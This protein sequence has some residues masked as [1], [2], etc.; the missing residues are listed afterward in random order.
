M[1]RLTKF[2]ETHQTLTP[3]DTQ[4]GAIAESAWWQ[5]VKPFFDD[6]IWQFY[7]DRIVFLN[8][9]FPED[10]STIAY[11]NIIRSFVINLKTK[12]R[13]YERI[14]EV[15]QEDYNPLWNVDGVT[16]IITK[17][18]HTGTDTVA[19]TGYDTSA[20][21]GSDRVVGSGNATDAQSGSDIN[22]LSGRDIDT[23]SGQ[24][25]NAQSGSDT[26]TSSL[27]EI[28]TVNYSK[29]DHTKTGSETI[30]SGGNDVNTKAVATFDSYQN[31]EGE[32]VTN[33]FDS[34]RDTLAHG[35]V[36]THNYNNVKDA[37]EFASTEGIDQDTTSNTQFGKTDTMQYGKVDTMQ[38]GK[39]DTTTYGKTDTNTYSKTDTTT[40]GKTDRMTYNSQSQDTKALEDEHLEMQIR[41]GNIGVT[42]SQQLL[43]A[44][45][46][47]WSADRANFIKRV[48]RDCVNIVTYAVEG[49]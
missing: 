39:T 42:M 32:L 11:Q 29:D 46:N 18:T 19:K 24:D 6:E 22:T 17:D 14:Y 35:K 8:R 43:D 13:Q 12:A 15:L 25:R 38:Y 23:L 37:H 36:D 10:D 16:G 33:L 34:E 21:S 48:V 2:L 4:M 7:D 27:D 3:T 45:L 31:V 30:S 49:V 40:Y 26:T 41:Q 9:K 28:K 20:Q 44:E 1:Y 47:A 5:Y